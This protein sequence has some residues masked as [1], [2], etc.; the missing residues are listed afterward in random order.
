[1]VAVP[2]FSPIFSYFFA[3]MDIIGGVIGLAALIAGQFTG[4]VAILV[5]IPAFLIGAKKLIR[6]YSSRK[7]HS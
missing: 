2:I 6:E 5:V 7:K 3:I 4:A 1:M